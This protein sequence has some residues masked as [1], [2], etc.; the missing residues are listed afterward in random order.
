MVR[1]LSSPNGLALMSPMQL[2]Y[3]N[4]IGLSPLRTVV[5]VVPMTHLYV[6]SMVEAEDRNPFAHK[7][8][9]LVEGLDQ[10][11]VDYETRRVLLA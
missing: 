4:Y 11:A 3:Q 7:K 2:Y 6:K 5:R 8:R 9:G 1:V 10:Y